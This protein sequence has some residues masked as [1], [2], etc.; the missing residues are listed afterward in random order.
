MKKLG[1]ILIVFGVLSFLGAASKEH[2]VIGP[3]FCI[4]IGGTMFYLKREK[5]E[6]RAV[7]KNKTDNE[8]IDVSQE[9][10]DN[11]SAE[12]L[13]S[14]VTMTFEQ[15]EAALCLIAFFAGYNDDVMSNDAAYLISRQSAVFYGIEN[16][17]RTLATAMRKFNDAD[18]LIDMVLTIKEKKAK[19][20]LLL[21]CYDL[22][23]MSEKNEAYEILYCIANDMG[24]NK[25]RLNLLIKQYSK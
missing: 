13:Y 18:R 3:L 14:E 17:E 10:N 12:T 16:Y 24:Y 1:W 5:T 19:E 9:Q 20:F 15:K 21:S 6:A 23:K 25:E 8:A 7:V 22:T 4:G 2:S 11:H